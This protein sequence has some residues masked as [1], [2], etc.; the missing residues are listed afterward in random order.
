MIE[1][2]WLA[3]FLRCYKSTID[4]LDKI[5]SETGYAYIRM[6]AVDLAT[7]VSDPTWYKG[8]IEIGYN[9]EPEAIA[10][11]LAHGLH[12]AVRDGAKKKDVFGE[13][14]CNTLR[15]YVED[16]MQTQSQWL[17][18]TDMAKNRFLKLY[19]SLNEFIDALKSGRIF[20]DTKW[21][22]KP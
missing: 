18:S 8:E 7:Q 3:Q 5:Q 14:F 22:K 21:P 12:E 15:Y 4:L 16:E 20:I 1:S 10:H 9:N 11:E 13:E 2:E 17:A 6:T 19:P